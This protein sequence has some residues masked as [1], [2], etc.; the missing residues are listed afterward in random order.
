[1]KAMARE[2]EDY[3]ANIERLNELYPDHEMLTI[4]ETMQVMGYRSIN[5]AKKHIPF[6]QRRVSK[7]ALAR[8]MCGK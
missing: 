6:T 3:R 4:A 7:A 1:M 8:I 2:K 5:T